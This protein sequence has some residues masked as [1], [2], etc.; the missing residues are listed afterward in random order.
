MPES[1]LYSSSAIRQVQIYLMRFYTEVNSYLQQSEATATNNLLLSFQI[2]SD[3]SVR[4]HW[5][6]GK[7]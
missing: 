1:Q 7:A 6:H 4:E 2:N 3:I 5:M